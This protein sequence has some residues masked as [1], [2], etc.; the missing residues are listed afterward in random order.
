MITQL[1]KNKVLSLPQ[2]L[3]T[4]QASWQLLDELQRVVGW[5]GNFVAFGRRFEIPRLQ[6]WYADEGIN[7]RYADNMLQTHAWIEPLVSI[8]RYVEEVSG[9]QFNSVLLTYYRNG[10][11]HV[12]WHAD[13]EVELG[14][15]PVIASL[16]LGS[17][18]EFHFRHNDRMDY[19]SIQLEGGNLL[20]MYPE[21][22]KS[23]QHCILPQVD[24]AE[25]RINLTFRR[26][27]TG[28]NI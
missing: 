13:D 11:D 1:V 20:V 14:D 19:G 7:Y 6:A 10:H 3:Y 28:T 2:C 9:H 27:M 16:S 21:F 17:K 18:R 25:R 12:A 26:V 22:Q 24:V 8:K 4:Q 5:Q 23:W 15:A